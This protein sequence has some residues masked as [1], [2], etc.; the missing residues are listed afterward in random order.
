METSQEKGRNGRNEALRGAPKTPLA[1]SLCHILLSDWDAHRFCFAVD[2][3]SRPPSRLKASRQPSQTIEKNRY[4][5]SITLLGILM[6]C[7]AL[8]E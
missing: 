1:V 2:T 8:F 4:P 3:V 7:F 6:C 5:A